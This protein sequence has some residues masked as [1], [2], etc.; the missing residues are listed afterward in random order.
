MN[1]FDGAMDYGLQYLN[2][3]LYVAYIIFLHLLL[4]LFHGEPSTETEGYTFKKLGSSPA[5][6]ANGDV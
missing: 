6:N 1:I 5:L 4:F 2:L 3:H